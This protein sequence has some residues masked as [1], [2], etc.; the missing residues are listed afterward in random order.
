MNKKEFRGDI[1]G[2]RA[3]AVIMVVL[4]HFNVPLISSGFAGVDVFFVISGYLMTKIIIERVCRNS[5]SFYGFYMARAIRIIPALVILCLFMFVVSLFILMP[6]DLTYFSLYAIR[7]IF[8][9]SNYYLTKEADG[10]FS[11]SAHDNLLLHTWSLSVEWQFYLLLPVFIILIYKVSNLKILKRSIVV[12]AVAS[13]ILCILLKN[14]PSHAYYSFPSRA[15][16]MLI[17]GI[18]FCYFNDNEKSNEKLSRFISWAGLIL[19]ISSSIVFSEKNTWPYFATLV[20]TLGAALFIL[21]RNNETFVSKNKLIQYIGTSSYSIYLWHWPIQVIFNFCQLTNSL[22]TAL[23]IALSF[24]LGFISYRFVEK[25]SKSWLLS[26]H[27]RQALFFISSTMLISCILFSVTIIQNGLPGRTSSDK[28]IAANRNIQLPLPSNGW[29]FY[30]VD[31]MENLKVGEEG[32]NCHIGSKKQNAKKVLLFG[33]SYAGQYI[34]FWD[35]IG[36]EDNLNIH[37]ITT[38][39]CYPSDGVDFNGVKASRAYKQCLLNR[40]FLKRNISNYDV[41]IFAGKWRNIILN[42]EYKAGFYRALNL[43]QQN[44]IKT[45]IMSEPYSFDV[46]IGKVYKRAAWLNFPFDIKKYM[47][48][49]L[50]RDQERSDDTLIRMTSGQP[51]ILLIKRDELYNKSQYAIKDIPYSWDGQHISVIGSLSSANYFTKKG[52]IEQINSFISK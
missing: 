13:F 25:P 23:A 9:L 3:L 14:H 16:E 20:P 48:G 10:Y 2:L 7:S 28:F 36:N 29:C 31:N 38:N 24:T 6:D 12:L 34:P 4:F 15:W 26:R 8:F 43:S 51:Y 19:I 22:F 37:A 35:T 45:I 32:L 49:E 47:N 52:G 30:S 11:P 27:K 42:D 40:D 17:G 39:W 5:F 1:N 46:D 44:K 21:A 18:V 33:D 41:V 50:K